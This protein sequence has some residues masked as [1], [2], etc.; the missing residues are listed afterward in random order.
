METHLPEEFTASINRERLDY[1][2]KH[3]TREMRAASLS[4]ASALATQSKRQRYEL[5][6][7]IIDDAISL[8]ALLVIFFGG[9]FV[10]WGLS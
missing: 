9:M 7:T 3:V 4:S 10:A 1:D 5:P 8:A 2:P 6:E